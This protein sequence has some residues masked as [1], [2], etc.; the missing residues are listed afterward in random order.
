MRRPVHF[1]IHADDPERASAFYSTVFGWRIEKWAGPADYWLVTTGPDGEPGING[2]IL[3]RQGPPPAA[4]A[5]VHGYVCTTE[6]P[7]LDDTVE[8]ATGAGGTVALPR[9]PVPGVGWLAYLEDTEGNLFGVL[10]PDPNAG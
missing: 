1:E 4:G 9:M 2:G 10:E 3:R 7:A 6:V 8:A 5:P